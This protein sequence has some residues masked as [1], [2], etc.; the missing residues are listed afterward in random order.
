MLL[1]HTKLQAKHRGLQ[2]LT[3]RYD[4][5]VL[6]QLLRLGRFTIDKPRQIDSGLGTTRGAVDA[7][8]VANLVTWT[9]ST[10]FRRSLIRQSC[11]REKSKSIASTWL[12]AAGTGSVVNPQPPTPNPLFDRT[13]EFKLYK[14]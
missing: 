11:K 5:V 8:P 10:Y 12:V 7:H 14:I 3:S 4:G 2:S 6:A 9:S 1:L 13:N